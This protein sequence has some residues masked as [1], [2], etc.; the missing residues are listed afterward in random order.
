MI[1][2]YRQKNGNNLHSR[3]EIPLQNHHETPDEGRNI[4]AMKT[5][6]RTLAEMNNKD[7]SSSQRFRKKIQGLV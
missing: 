3:F 5:K 4:V 7:D 2:K 1:S 6:T